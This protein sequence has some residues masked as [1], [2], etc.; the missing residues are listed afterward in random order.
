MLFVRP[1]F[2]EGIAK[3]LIIYIHGFQIPNMFL[4]LLLLPSPPE[5]SRRKRPACALSLES[6]ENNLSRSKS[7]GVDISKLP[8]NFSH[9]LQKT[10]LDFQSPSAQ[11]TKL[12]ACAFPRQRKGFVMDEKVDLRE[13]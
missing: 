11:D 2:S 4:V 6:K 13:L 1:P 9:H 10:P 12:Q 7:N 5:L 8:V 3:H